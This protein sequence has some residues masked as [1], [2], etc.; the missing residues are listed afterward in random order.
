MTFF[1]SLFSRADK[2]HKYWQALQLRKKLTLGRSFERARL[3]GPGFSPDC[4]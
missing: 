2:T 3:V 4:H 1:S